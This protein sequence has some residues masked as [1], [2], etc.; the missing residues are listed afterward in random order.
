MLI[1]SRIQFAVTIMFHYIFPCISIGLAWFVLYFEFRGQKNEQYAALGKFFG[2][3]LALTFVFGVASGIVME[4][5]FGTNWSRYS[6]FVG[7]IFGA[8]LAAEA[9][10]AFFLEST[11][12]GIYLWGRNKVKPA[13]HLFSILMVTL[14]TTLSAFWI[15]AANSW[16]QTP[17]GHIIR[18]GRAELESFFE[19]IFNPSTL[20]RFF[21]T[22]NGSIVAGSFLV[23]GVCAY[24][25]LKNKHI[26]M[27]QKSLVVG[28]IVGL[29]SSILQLFPFGHVHAV[30]VGKTQPAKL[31]AMEGVYK[32]Q[33][34]SPFIIL[35]Y[36][37]IEDDEIRIEPILEIPSLLSILV[38]GD[39]DAPV[40]G[41][42]DIPVE[43]RPPVFPVW[44][45]FHIMVGLG[46]LFILVL[47]VGVYKLLRK[48][49]WQASTLMKILV[50]MIPLP[51][52]ANELGWVVAEM[53]RQPW[54]VYGLLRTEQAHSPVVSDGEVF[55]SL[56]SFG[57][58]Y[59]ILGLLYLLLMYKEITE[60]PDDQTA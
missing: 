59:L 26:E 54:I 31:A 52:L 33:A 16:Q 47:L 21:H 60:G 20:P 19:V 3:L 36:P 11:F 55:F 44:L 12:L 18:N 51:V 57:V 37:V 29:V 4:F 5:Q 15:V 40:T 42:D 1:L 6:Q 25:I 14:G 28:L 53:G 46:T 7:D 56:I 39:A 2:K 9:I 27:A 38:H 43:N 30:Q 34:E 50:I 13:V 45:S 49:L 41:L 35:A 8:P 17:A 10:F 22:L 23:M 24:F 48:R 58:I 32:T